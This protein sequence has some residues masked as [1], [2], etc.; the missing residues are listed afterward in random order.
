[1]G[2]VRRREEPQGRIAGVAADSH[3]TSNDGRHIPYRGKAV[4]AK[5]LLMPLC[6]A[7]PAEKLPNWHTAKNL[8][9]L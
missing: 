3:P 7:R 8:Q 9:K 5:S 6:A 1:M 4:R 2:T